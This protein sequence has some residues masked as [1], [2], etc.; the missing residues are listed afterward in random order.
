[1]RTL[2]LLI[3]LLLLAMQ[4]QAEPLP[5]RAEEAL[6]QEQLGED[7]QGISISLGGEESTALQ[8]A[9]E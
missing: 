5:R 2:I 6:D 7:D 4:T 8:D 3:A 9:G 1:M